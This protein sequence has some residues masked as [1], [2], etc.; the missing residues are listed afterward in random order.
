MHET[1]FGR[2]PCFQIIFRSARRVLWA[3]KE[4][5]KQMADKRVHIGNLTFLKFVICLTSRRV[6]CAGSRTRKETHRGQS[7]RCDR[8]RIYHVRT[9]WKSSQ[10]PFNNIGNDRNPKMVSPWAIAFDSNS[11]CGK[12]FDFWFALGRVH[13]FIIWKICGRARKIPHARAQQHVFVK[14]AITLLMCFWYR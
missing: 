12:C 9:I 7:A 6:T 4:K 13:V 10:S 3:H 1:E 5:R 8:L 11:A 2:A 14:N